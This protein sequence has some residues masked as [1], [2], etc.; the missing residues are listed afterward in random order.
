MLQHLFCPKCK[1]IMK[2]VG[3]KL[4]CECGFEAVLCSEENMK[5]DKKHTGIV[6][7]EN[8]FANYPH[9]C[10]KCGFDK[11]ELIFIQPMYTDADYI[12]RY[13]CGKCGYTEQ[14][15]MRFT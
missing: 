1:K 6:K 7:G 14:E 9:Q 13:K 8:E 12:I 15:R 2:K 3:N 10:K 5:K 11:A 4:V